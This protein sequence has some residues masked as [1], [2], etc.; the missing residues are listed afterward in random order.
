MSQLKAILEGR[1]KPGVHVLGTVVDVRGS[2]YR[3]PGAR[4][5]IS[6]DGSRTGMIS[7]GC[8]DKDVARH[9]FDWT[10]EGPQTVLYDTRGDELNPRGKYGSGCDGI[11]ELLLERVVPGGVLDLMQEVTTKRECLAL[12][13]VYAG[14]AVAPGTRAW[15][16]SG[17][18]HIDEALKPLEDEIGIL[19]SESESWRRPKSVTITIDEQDVVCLVEF[20]APPAELLIVGA[21]DDAR[22]LAA[23][24]RSMDWDVTV[25]DKWPALATHDRFPGAEVVCVEPQHLFGH[26]NVTSQ[27]YVAMMTHNFDDDVLLLPQFIDSAAPWVGLMGPRSR[28]VG[29]IRALKEQGRM[30]EVDALIK[31][32]TPIGIDL[33]S[34]SPEE[35]ALSVM[36]G[37]VAGKNA[38]EAGLLRNSQAL[39]IHEEHAR[40]RIED[41]IQEAS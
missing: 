2:A 10:A 16:T 18:F 32:Q 11:V 4:V 31:L 39:T 40:I 37:V 1:A 17:G 21:G 34:D 25:V 41:L 26:V 24:A 29:I 36:A 7:G 8:L 20:I 23:I 6:P 5:L 9:A 33:A 27:T 13:T 22:P 38:A 12:L 19:L 30:P 15:R 35:V 3:R 28:T 14:Q